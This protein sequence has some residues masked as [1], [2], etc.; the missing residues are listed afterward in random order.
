GVLDLLAVVEPGAADDLVGDVGAHELLL[1]DAALRVGAVEDGDV[2]PPERPTVA[3]L[4]LVAVVEA[5]DLPGDPLR[6]VDLVVGVVADDR[7]AL[8]PVGPQLLGL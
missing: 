8:A 6:L 2:A 5:G 1:E 3:A 7:V 4:D